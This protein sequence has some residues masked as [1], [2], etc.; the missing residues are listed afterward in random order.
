[1]KKE[2][3]IGNLYGQN[4]YNMTTCY[5]PERKIGYIHTPRCAGTNISRTLITINGFIR[6]DYD[7]DWPVTAY[8]PLL[9]ISNISEYTLISVVRHPVTWLWSGYN[10]C[11]RYWSITFEK[12]LECIINPWLLLSAKHKDKD[13]MKK[14]LGWYWHCCILP[15]KHLPDRTKIF[16]FEKLDQL[17]NFLNIKIYNKEQWKDDSNNTT[18]SPRLPLFTDYEKNLIKQITNSY[19]EKWDYE[20]NF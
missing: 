13:L 17:E 18:I 16:K 11:N 7:E 20:F 1:M 12:H 9:E 3:Q 19:A 10:Y 2:K 4:L 5:H 8:E 14:F 6:V 15:D